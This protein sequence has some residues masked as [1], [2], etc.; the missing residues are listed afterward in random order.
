MEATTIHE[1]VRE[2]YGELARTSNSCCNSGSR[3]LYDE[4]L[5]QALRQV[6]PR[7]PVDDDDR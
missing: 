2:H 6:A 7:V 5:I 3:T 4:Q 1:A